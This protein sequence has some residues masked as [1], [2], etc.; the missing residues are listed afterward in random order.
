MTVIIPEQVSSLRK[1]KLELEKFLIS[2]GY[3]IKNG[4]IILPDKNYSK[5]YDEIEHEVKNRLEEY[6]EIRNLLNNSTFLKNRSLDKVEVGTKFEVRFFDDEET[7]SMILV[8]KLNGVPS[9]L[10]FVSIE[11]PLGK[12]IVG[13]KVGEEFSYK[14]D[15]N[16]RS[17]KIDCSLVSIEN[18]KD[19][20]INFLRDDENVFLDVITES[21]KQL[22]IEEKERLKNKNDEAERVS[23]IDSLLEKSTTADM[24]TDY[25]GIG[26]KFKIKFYNKLD[27]NNEYEL[28]NR[29][30]S[31][32]LSDSYIET[33]SLVGSHIVGLKDNDTFIFETKDGKVEGKIYDLKKKR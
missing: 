29:A 25:V 3:S 28:I 16:D 14:I 6:K 4:D 9:T 22:L 12:S 21:Q 30:V 24:P 19:N 5:D 32:E 13:H 17:V 31:D 8:D 27:S 11:S 2:N 20:Y 33:I 18:N 15:D 23:F 26:S 7:E 1:Q 10:G